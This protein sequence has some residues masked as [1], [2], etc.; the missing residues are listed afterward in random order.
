MLEP[1]VRSADNLL[2]LRKDAAQMVQDLTELTEKLAVSGKDYT[3]EVKEEVLQRIDTQ[4]HELSSRM[5]ELGDDIKAGSAKVDLHVKSHPYA[6]ILG[7]VGLGFLLGKVR[8]ISE[9]S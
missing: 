5:K 1:K 6:Y 3:K 2:A 7:A 9:K 4:M 8:N